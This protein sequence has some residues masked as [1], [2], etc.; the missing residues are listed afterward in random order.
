MLAYR[1]C[2]LRGLDQDCVAAACSPPRA[3]VRKSMSPNGARSPRQRSRISCASGVLGVA[4]REQRLFITGKCRFDVV[5]VG[6]DSLPELG[7]VE[8]RQVRALAGRRHQVRGVTQQRHPGHAVPAVPVRERVDR[9]RDWCGFAVGNQRGQ[10][11]RPATMPLPGV[12]AYIA[13]PPTA[14]AVAGCRS[15]ASYR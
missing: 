11:R 5:G 14:S 10:L 9:A 8:H 6:G 1:G 3:P 15:S 13:P 2:R 7:A 12:S 4:A